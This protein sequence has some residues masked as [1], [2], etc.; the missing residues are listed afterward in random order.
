MRTLD[1]DTVLLFEKIN[2][3]REELDIRHSASLN[4]TDKTSRK[5]VGKKTTLREEA[6]DIMAPRSCKDLDTP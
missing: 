2:H 1:N 3:P 6:T 4:L 5:I